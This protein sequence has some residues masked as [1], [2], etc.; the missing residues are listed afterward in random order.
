MTTRSRKPGGPSN[1]IRCRFSRT[2]TWESPDHRARRYDDALKQIE[3]TLRM[4]PNYMLG[5]LNLGLILAARKSYDAAALAFQRASSYSP[6]YEDA[7]GLLAYAYA[8]GGATR[9]GE[10][11]RSGGSSFLAGAP[12]VGICSRTLLPGIRRRGAGYY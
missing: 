9:G 1:S 6:A 2:R 7:R 11:D 10:S 3:Q 5:H 12:H 4:D 8:E